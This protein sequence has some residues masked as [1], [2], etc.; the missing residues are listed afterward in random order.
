MTIRKLYD[1]KGARKAKGIAV[2][3]DILRA[4]TVQAYAFAKGAK[5]IICVSTKEEA[6]N[7]KK[8][9]PEFL[10]M[11]ENNGIKIEGFDLS[12]SPSEILKTNLENKTL[13][14]RS[15]RGTQALINTFNAK[16]IIFGSFVICSSIVSYIR[17]REPEIVSIAA[18][19]EEDE[20]FADYLEK[21]LLGEYP[22]IEEVRN[23]LYNHPN[24]QW[25]FDTQKEAFPKEDVDLALE[26]DKFNFI[27][28]VEKENNQLISRK[29]TI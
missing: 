9:N 17:N 15:T 3:I 16:E 24:T 10:L 12:N 18:I 2:V 21:R 22:N 1:V 14:H 6:F 23:K 28:F 25:Y 27:C 11:G 8:Q 4:S 7:L 19:D 29:I 20:I 5:E 13:V 26:I